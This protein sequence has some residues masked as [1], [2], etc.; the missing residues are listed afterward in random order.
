M[1]E[2]PAHRER[3]HPSAVGSGFWENADQA[4][5]PAAPHGSLSTVTGLSL[6]IYS[7]KELNQTASARLL[8]GQFE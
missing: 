7:P 6:S 2:E 1:G 8:Q 4:R 5:K 3:R